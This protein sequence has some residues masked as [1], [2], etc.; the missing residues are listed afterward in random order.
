[1]NKL[2]QTT[3]I[4]VY[5]S[6]PKNNQLYITITEKIRYSIWFLNEVMEM[7]ER[8]INSSYESVYIS[9]NEKII[10]II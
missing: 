4:F 6:N 5:N 10:L 8:I 9:Y 3:N 7:M 2:I 1:M